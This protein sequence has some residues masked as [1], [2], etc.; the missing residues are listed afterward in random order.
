MNECKH[1]W[2]AN[3]NLRETYSFQAKIKN[4]QARK[5]VNN[6][7]VAAQNGPREVGETDNDNDG[8]MD[9]EVAQLPQDRTGGELVPHNKSNMEYVQPLALGEGYGCF[10]MGD[11]R[12]GINKKLVQDADDAEKG[13][14][15]KQ[16]REWRAYAGGVCGEKTCFSGSVYPGCLDIYGFCC[17]TIMSRSLYEMVLDQ[18]QAMVRNHRRRHVSVR[19]KKTT[20]SGPDSSIDH[21]FLV[22]W[23]AAESWTE[24]LSCSTVTRRLSLHIQ[25]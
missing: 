23:N 12:F 21:P 2:S 4:Q 22:A 24:L 11:R 6:E 13:F 5:T 20:N 14:V 19:G 15:Q 8:P 9:S 3:Q 17:K 1:R 10:G 18:L 7:L 25:F 16:S